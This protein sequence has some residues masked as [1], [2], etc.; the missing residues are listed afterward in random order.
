MLSGDRHKT[1]TSPDGRFFNLQVTDSK[2][3]AIEVRAL[4]TANDASLAFDLRCAVR[5]AMLAYICTE[6]PEAIVRYRGVVRLDHPVV[7][8][9]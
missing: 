5:E 2:P 8:S 7:S 3:E 6:M 1:V 9:T 4:M